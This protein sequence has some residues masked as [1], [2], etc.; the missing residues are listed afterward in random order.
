MNGEYMFTPC[1]NPLKK[2]MKSLTIKV[3]SHMQMFW[4][5]HTAMALE[6][7][8]M[9]LSMHATWKLGEVGGI[10]LTPQFPF[11]KEKKK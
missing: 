1:I 2:V 11:P 10:P 9:Y 3:M 5:N 7:I 8:L 6:L 4:T